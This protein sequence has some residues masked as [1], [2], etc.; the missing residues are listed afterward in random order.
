M[1]GASRFARLP[2]VQGVD[3]PPKVVYNKYK[4]NLR[5]LQ[6]TQ[7]SNESDAIG[8]HVG[9]IVICCLDLQLCGAMVRLGDSGINI[10]GGT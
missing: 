3:Y 10:V 6:T 8:Q 2:G 1:W 4:Y 7:H 5:Y 9:E